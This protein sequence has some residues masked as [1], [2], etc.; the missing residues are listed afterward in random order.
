M[1]ERRRAQNQTEAWA[2]V[3]HG[4]CLGEEAFRKELLAQVSERRGAHHY[5]AELQEGEEEKAERLVQEELVRRKWSEQEL[6]RK[7]KTGRHKARIALRLRRKTTMTMEWIARRL[8][9]GSVNALKNALR[10]YN[11][12]D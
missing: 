12:R 2:P 6:E 9:M 3:R 10:F 8:Q 11:S 7:P 4:W 5:G 1:E